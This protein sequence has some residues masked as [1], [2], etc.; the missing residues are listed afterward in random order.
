VTAC[1]PTGLVPKG[2]ILAKD[3]WFYSLLECCIEK[4]RFRGDGRLGGVRSHGVGGGEMSI[5]NG[6]LEEV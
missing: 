5:W 3:E 2:M 4:V 1:S 6:C